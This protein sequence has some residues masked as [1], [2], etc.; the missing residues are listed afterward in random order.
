MRTYFIGILSL[1]LLMACQNRQTNAGST[2]LTDSIVQQP[3]TVHKD[4][5]VTVLAKQVLTVLKGKDYES[6]AHFIHPVIGVRFSPYGHIDTAADKVFSTGAFLDELSKNPQT[7]I[8]WGQYDGTGEPIVLTI[9]AY[10][11]KFVYN[12]DFLN[13]PQTGFNKIIGKGNAVNNLTVVYKDC[14]F[15]EHHFPGFDQK[16]NGMDWCSL[17]LVFKNYH[18]KMY[19]VGVVHD[20]WTI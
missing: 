20:Q 1:L 11:N 8:T 19:L 2:I 6:F 10:F 7:T 13:A 16:Y 5:Q 3:D 12:A 18:N 17:R 4:V 9:E 15:T 14:D